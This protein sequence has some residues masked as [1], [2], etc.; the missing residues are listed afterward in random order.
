MNGTTRTLQPTKH[1]DKPIVALKGTDLPEVFRKV[2]EKNPDWA[3]C[4]YEIRKA[5][6]HNG[7]RLQYERALESQLRTLEKWNKASLYTFCAS[8]AAAIAL[9]IGNCVGTFHGELENHINDIYVFLGTASA[10]T[11]YAITYAIPNAISNLLKPLAQ[12]NGNSL[13]K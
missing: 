3:E 11:G 4:D 6:H 12:L 2:L 13:K 7:R 1:D 9:S 5:G 10:F 8:A